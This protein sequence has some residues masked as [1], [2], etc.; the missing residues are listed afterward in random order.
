LL[1]CRPLI[2]AAAA[3]CLRRRCSATAPASAERRRRGKSTVQ[4]RQR[5]GRGVAVSQRKPGRESPAR[6]VG[7]ARPVRHSTPT[8]CALGRPS[9]NEINTFNYAA[10]TKREM[11]AN[12]GAIMDEF[13]FYYGRRIAS[14][15]GCVICWKIALMCRRKVTSV[16]ALWRC[17]YI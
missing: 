4:R 12:L 2:A 11:L 16:S 6:P 15:T 5:I 14:L 13:A 10:H 17:V 3:R 7:I 9:V 8:L 1:P